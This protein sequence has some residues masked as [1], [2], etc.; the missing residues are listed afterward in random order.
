VQARFTDAGERVR[1]VSADTLLAVLRALGA[2]VEEG[3]EVTADVRAAIEERRRSEQDRLVEPV[4]LAWGGRLR[5]PLVHEPARRRNAKVRLALTLEDG[6]TNHPGAGQSGD[7]WVELEEDLPLGYHRLEV[8]VGPS[9]ARALVIAAPRT[10]GGRSDRTWGVFLP[11]YAVRTSRDWGVG[12]LTDLGDLL[13][14]TARAG[15][16]L[17]ATLPMLSAFLDGGAFEPSPYSPASRLFWN[18]LYL[19]VE[20]SPEVAASPSARA[21]MEHGAFRRNLTALRESDTIDYRAVAARKREVLAAAA[22]DFF[23]GSST[24]RR[25]A[26]DAFERADPKVRD[27]AA[28]MAATERHGRTW[29]GWPA[30]ERDG[31]LARDG[32]NPPGWRYHRFVQWQLAEQLDRVG[33]RARASGGGLYVDFPL[34]VNP[35]G[36]DAW[37]ERA[38]FATGASAGAPPDPFF[39]LGQDWGFH[40]LHPDG[41]REQGYA[42]PIE[43]FRRSLAR[44]GVLRIDHVMGL[45]R[46][47]FVPAGRPPA[48]GAYVR[49]RHEELYAILAL[50]A[51]RSGSVVVGED[52]GTVRTEVRRAMARH[53]IERSYVVQY[54]VLDH[55]D[56]RIGAPPA[57]SLA[58]VNT[59]DMP[60]FS[61]FWRA[62]DVTYRAEQGWLDTDAA[63]R[64]R[65]A[66]AGIRAALVAHLRVEGWLPE[67]PDPTAREVLRA[68]LSW[69]AAGDAR[70]VVAGLEDLWGERRPQNVPGTTDEYPNWRRRARHPLERLDRV[71]GLRAT[72]RTIDEMR[73]GRGR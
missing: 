33:E 46:L 47:W 21:A 44:S 51:R 50:E 43:A 26:L 19:D 59:H 15:G 55:P 24:G 68:C 72:L 25:A 69:L 3:R 63:R 34:G 2:P 49:Y 52:L 16:H 35:G 30:R 36:Y 18:E 7:R 23:A 57:R 14:W 32:G 11:L 48:E 54:E 37:R 27:Y 4:V 5:G 6:T 22:E 61:A 12:D 8:E 67:G 66:R 56:A 71:P 53:G 41:V 39:P 60:P 38:A 17:V 58:T 73:M 28:F 31:R 9:R 40:P 42:Y 10:P 29:Q 62:D 20:A 45:H 13:E 64:E 70:I 1:N 65:A